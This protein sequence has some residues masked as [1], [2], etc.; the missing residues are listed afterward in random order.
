GRPGRRSCGNFSKKS[1]LIDRGRTSGLL[2]II[3]AITNGK[4]LLSFDVAAAIQITTNTTLA[5][6]I[7]S[8]PGNRKVTVS[9]A[10]TSPR[11]ARK[12]TLSRSP[13]TPRIASTATIS[14]GGNTPMLVPNAGIGPV[15]SDSSAHVVVVSSAAY[16]ATSTGRRAVPLVSGT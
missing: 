8:A 3:V 13:N 4:C 9:V 7:K 1:R 10:Y 2:D 16:R 5:A 15:P 14:H 12:I 11:A 6:T